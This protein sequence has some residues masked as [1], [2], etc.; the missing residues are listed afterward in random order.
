MFY[1]SFDILST[2]DCSKIR[3]FRNCS[4]FVRSAS[5]FEGLEKRKLAKWVLSSLSKVQVVLLAIDWVWIMS[6]W[7]RKSKFKMQLVLQKIP[8]LL[9]EIRWNSYCIAII[10]SLSPSIPSTPFHPTRI[11]TSPTI[12]K[13][14]LALATLNQTYARSANT[15]DIISQHH[16]TTNVSYHLMQVQ[17]TSCIWQTI[18]WLFSRYTYY[19][20]HT[21]IV[22]VW[23]YETSKRATLHNSTYVWSHII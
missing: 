20:L 2:L 9:R 19:A 14:S 10:T 13:L 12:Q 15:K 4:E 21:I 3:Y 7:W 5:A 23:K 6:V 17:W 22:P 8:F 11:G 1:T 18:L 16:T